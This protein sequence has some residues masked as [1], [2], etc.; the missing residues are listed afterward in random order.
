MLARVRE[1]TLQLHQRITF[2]AGAFLNGLDCGQLCS[3]Q[4]RG[5]LPGHRVDAVLG[6]RPLIGLQPMQVVDGTGQPAVRLLDDPMLIG[7]LAIDVLQAAAQFRD[8][9]AA[10]RK[11]G[12]QALF[13][14]ARFNEL[15]TTVR[16]RRLRRI[17]K[18]VEPI[19]RT[20]ARSTEGLFEATALC[21]KRFDNYFRR[22]LLGCRWVL[23]IIRFGTVVV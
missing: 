11:P 19:G 2:G 8:V 18:M 23:A 12:L 4:V 9:L 22:R 16:R 7:D 5:M 6:D 10:L 20:V 17:A 13:G 15:L 14:I 1:L 3:G 21:A